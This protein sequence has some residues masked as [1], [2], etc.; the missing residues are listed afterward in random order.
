MKIP[1]IIS[2]DL[3]GK[4]KDYET[5]I[6]NIESYSTHFKITESCWIV[7]TDKSFNSF[8]TDLVKDLDDDD[9]IFIAELTY[10]VAAANPLCDFESLSK[11]MNIYKNAKE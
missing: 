1:Y 6:S 7:F 4:D 10:N 5:L 11:E 8:G 3:C 9:R 2:Y